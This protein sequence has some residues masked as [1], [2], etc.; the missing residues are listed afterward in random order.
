MA[1]GLTI[2]V[3]GLYIAYTEITHKKDE[4]KFIIFKDIKVYTLSEKEQVFI[5]VLLAS[6]NF[7]CV[8]FQKVQLR[9]TSLFSPSCVV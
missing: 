7:K 6:E 2:L 5:L 8:C 1:S 4:L 9:K 3:F